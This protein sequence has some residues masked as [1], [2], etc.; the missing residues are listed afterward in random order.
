MTDV[1][2][3]YQKGLPFLFD[4]HRSG[5][6]PKL[7]AIHLEQINILVEEEVLTE[8]SGNLWHM[9]ALIEHVQFCTP[10][11][12]KYIATVYGLTVQRC[13][14]AVRLIR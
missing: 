5:A 6:P 1:R 2:T 10:K 11:V 8:Y 4:V 9:A 7:N 13:E 12:L 14:F 3:G